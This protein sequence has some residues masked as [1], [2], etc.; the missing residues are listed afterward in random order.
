MKNTGGN[1]P[2]T[3]DPRTAGLYWGFGGSGDKRHHCRETKA[4][5]VNYKLKS[6]T[7]LSR[8]PLS[9]ARRALAQASLAEKKRSGLSL[10]V[11]STDYEESANNFPKFA[12][13]STRR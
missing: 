10:S 7:L 2:F 11:I 8:R 1:A 13:S 9:R 5:S 12:T 4:K 6:V 3:L